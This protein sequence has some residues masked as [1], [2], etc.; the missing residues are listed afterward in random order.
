MTLA[1][2]DALAIALMRHRDFTPEN[3]R[4]FHPGGKLGAR[5]ARVRELMHTGDTLPL[6]AEATPMSEALIEMTAKGFGVVGVTDPAGAL[7]GI[8][9]DGDLRRHLDGDILALTAG[10]VMTRSPKTVTPDTLASAA[11]E[12]LNSA[13]ITSLFVVEDDRPVGIVHI[14]DL[15]RIGVR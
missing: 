13:K 3:F 5:L 9:T 8:V 11:L 1:L 4:E 7:T 14:H 12:Q 6:V 15:L 2:G 10:E